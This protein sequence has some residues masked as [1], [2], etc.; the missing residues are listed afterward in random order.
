MSN[1]QAKPELD[2]DRHI[3]VEGL[4]KPSICLYT[5]NNFSTADIIFRKLDIGDL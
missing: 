1:D 2:F 4:L 5:C 3:P